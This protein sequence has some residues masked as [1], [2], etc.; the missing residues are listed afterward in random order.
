MASLS[1]GVSGDVMHI[2]Q[3]LDYEFNSLREEGFDI[4]IQEIN[5]GTTTF[6]GC[7]VIKRGNGRVS[8]EDLAFLCRHYIANALSDII[9]DEW[10]PKLIGKIIKEHYHYFSDKEKE[11]I[12]KNTCESLNGL[13]TREPTRSLRRRLNWK[14]QILK[15]LLEYLENHSEVNLEGFITFR[16]KDY[17]EELED[18]VD[19]AVDEILLEHEYREFIN[20]LRHFVEV[21][22]SRVENVNVYLYSSGL[23]QLKDGEDRIIKDEL[24]DELSIYTLEGEIEYDDLLISSLVTLAPQ[25]VVVHSRRLNTSGLALDTLRSVFSERLE[26]CHGCTWCNEGGP[27]D[28]RGREL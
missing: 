26:F 5:R 23:F 12:L 6:L 28:G 9:V 21:Q 1:I 17:I 22:Q 13:G 3:R 8:P 16:L 24:M 20:L 11:A 18:A 2:R 27:Q 25:H 14:T 19:Q 15:K 10:E 4:D 7:S